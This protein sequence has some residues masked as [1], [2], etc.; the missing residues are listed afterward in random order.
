MSSAVRHTLAIL[1]R[2]CLPCLGFSS[3]IAG[4]DDPARA[5]AELKSV[6]SQID[7]MTSQVSRDAIARDKLARELKS[8]EAS[9][10]DA[11]GALERLRRERAERN[12]RRAELAAERR[13]ET[14]ALADARASLAGQIRAAHMIGRE[15]PLKLL[16]NQKDPALLGRVFTYYGY[17]GHARAEK[18]ATIEAHVSQ[19]NALDAALAEQEQQLLALESSVDC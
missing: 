4:Q 6:R 2:L 19:I 18:I 11:R 9:V 8:A 1:L 17:F 10:G 15:E 16:L 7:K 5:E 12:A 14:A 3:A 13:S